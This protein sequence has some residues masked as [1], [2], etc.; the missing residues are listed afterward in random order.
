[1]AAKPRKSTRK[2]KTQPKPLNVTVADLKKMSRDRLY[3]LSARIDLRNRSIMKK[4]ELQEALIEYVKLQNSST[5]KSVSIKSPSISASSA[6]LEPAVKQDP[7]ETGIFIDWGAPIPNHY[8]N[9]RIVAM[10]RDPHWLFI[11][12]EIEGSMSN[13]ITSNYGSDIFDK[14]QWI[15]RAE[16]LDDGIREDIPILPDYKNWYL[17]VN[18]EGRY[19]VKIGLL[20]PDNIFITLAS[21]DVVSTPAADPSERT[22]QEWSIDDDKFKEMMKSVGIDVDKECWS[23][24]GSSPRSWSPG[25]LGRDNN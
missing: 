22:D 21:S 20:T 16:F 6:P 7:Q 25:F 11:Y 17:R 24:S 18:P 15:L 10:V 19:K 12:W 8:G 5:K 4:D 14:S 1:M 23:F 9:D 2:R 3:S 13:D